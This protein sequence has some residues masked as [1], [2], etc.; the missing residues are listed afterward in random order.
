MSSGLISGMLPGIPDCPPKLLSAPLFCTSVV[1]SS[2]T[3]II[4]ELKVMV[5]CT[6]NSSSVLRTRLDYIESTG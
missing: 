6:L 5:I 2:L 4:M 1:G 3:I